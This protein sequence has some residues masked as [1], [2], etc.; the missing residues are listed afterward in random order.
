MPKKLA[1]AEDGAM[2]KR[3]DQL[4]IE[5]FVFPYG[6]LNPENEWVKLAELVLWD[7]VEERYAAQF[8]NNGHPAHP[9]RVALGALIIK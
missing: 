4:R 8:E 3:N 1:E 6:K 7:V 9:A 2:Y 5:D